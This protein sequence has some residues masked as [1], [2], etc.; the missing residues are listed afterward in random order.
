[1]TDF[2]IAV[3]RFDFTGLGRSGG[4][5][6]NTN[7]SS[8]IEDLVHGS[9]LLRERFA[10]PSFLIGHSLGGAAVPAQPTTSRRCGPWQPSGPTAAPDH[11][12]HLLRGNRTE[13][14]ECGEGTGSPSS[15]SWQ[16][17]NFAEIHRLMMT[18]RFHG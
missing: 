11:A 15:R 10:A 17:N 13:I 7:F 3:L 8:N 6:A 16:G 18:R 9:N 2:G 1:M 4:D 14:E 5:F 12:A